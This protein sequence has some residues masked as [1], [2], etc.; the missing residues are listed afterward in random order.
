MMA[1]RFKLKLKL[2]QHKKYL[3]A[4]KTV[5]GQNYNVL[6]LESKNKSKVVPLSHVGAKGERKYSSCSFLTSALEGVSGQ[7]HALAE[8]YTRER[9][10]GTHGI[11]GWVGLR[12]GL[13]TQDTGKNCLHPPGIELRSSS[14]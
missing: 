10:S 4:P 6:Y 13:D 5:A 2:S 1:G 7:H 12:A 14:L 11:G 3:A 8:L 9:I